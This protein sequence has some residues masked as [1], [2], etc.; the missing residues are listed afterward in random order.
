MFAGLFASFVPQGAALS[1]GNKTWMA[2][3]SAAMADEIR[4]VRYRV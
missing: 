4:C 1:R 3:P 2:A